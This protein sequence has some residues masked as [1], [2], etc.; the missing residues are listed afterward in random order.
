MVA[1]AKQKHETDINHT[2]SAVN[3]IRNWA[4]P[5]KK[6]GGISVHTTYITGMVRNRPDE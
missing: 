6:S 3:L 1:G 4:A 5:L 2:I